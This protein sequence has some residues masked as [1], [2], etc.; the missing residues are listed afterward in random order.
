VVG[1]RSLIGGGGVWTYSG[2]LGKYYLVGFEVKCGLILFLSD[3]NMI[4]LFLKKRISPHLKIVGI[5]NTERLLW[6]AFWGQGS[7]M[8]PILLCGTL[9]FVLTA[10]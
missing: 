4:L 6:L 7:C 9:C 8:F 10:P 5:I 3:N 1:K 2:L